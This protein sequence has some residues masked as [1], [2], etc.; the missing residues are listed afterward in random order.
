MNIR[1]RCIEKLKDKNKLRFISKNDIVEYLSNNFDVAISKNIKKTELIDILEGTLKEESLLLFVES[2]PEMGLT[3][4]E[5][6]ELYGCS[7]AQL[8]RF[9]NN[10]RLKSRA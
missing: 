1:E 5:I 4:F 9:V 7:K 3:Q 6:S 2:F 10:S 8:N